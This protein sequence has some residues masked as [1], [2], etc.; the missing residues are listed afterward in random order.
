ML[1]LYKL[2][3]GQNIFSRIL[4][5]LHTDNQ[6]TVYAKNSDIEKGFLGKIKLLSNWMYEKPFW[7]L[8]VVLP[9][10]IPV[11]FYASCRLEIWIIHWFDFMKHQEA[12]KIIRL[13]TGE[14]NNANPYPVLTR[15][16]QIKFFR[17]KIWKLFVGSII[18]SD[19][20]GL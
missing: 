19:W 7:L 18:I 9:S 3:S 2:N 20:L 12:A 1:E 5:L 16:F 4:F 13:L 10:V 17:N 8:S 14:E 15:N 6:F 11:Y